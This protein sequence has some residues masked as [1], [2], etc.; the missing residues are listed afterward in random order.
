MKGNLVNCTTKIKQRLVFFLIAYDSWSALKF[1]L[2]ISKQMINLRCFCV[3]SD[4]ISIFRMTRRQL[5]CMCHAEIRNLIWNLFSVTCWPNIRAKQIIPQHEFYWLN[6]NEF[7]V[8]TS[9]TLQ[10]IYQTNKFQ[11][12]KIHFLT[13]Q[14]RK[15]RVTAQLSLI[16]FGWL[17]W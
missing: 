9:N 17:V 8:W 2:N 16:L 4:Y 7:K 13:K 3:N 14:S 6:H 12:G 1:L 5:R 10:S 15:K 11:L